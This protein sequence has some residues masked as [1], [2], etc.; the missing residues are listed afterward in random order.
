MSE[1]S[2]FVTDTLRYFN[3]SDRAQ[4]AQALM[5]H[6]AGFS[7]ALIVSDYDGG[8]YAVAGIARS[9]WSGGEYEDFASLE[10]FEH[11]VSLLI[12]CESGKV[13]RFNLRTGEW[14]SVDLK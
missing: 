11:D 5:K 12:N 7:P 14:A 13:I 10:P 3:D 9:S 1:R 6:L 4:I 8:P 2:T